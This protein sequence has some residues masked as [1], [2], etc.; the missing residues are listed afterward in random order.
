M[1][2]AL[3]FVKKFWVE[4]SVLLLAVVSFLTPSLEAYEKSHASTSR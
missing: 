4:H 1:S 2:K 3:A